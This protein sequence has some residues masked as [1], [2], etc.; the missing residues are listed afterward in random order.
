M[1]VESHVEMQTIE[2]ELVLSCFS[3][4]TSDV[5]ETLTLPAMI[6]LLPTTWN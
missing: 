1:D 2:H 5:L 4:D 3:A 6:V